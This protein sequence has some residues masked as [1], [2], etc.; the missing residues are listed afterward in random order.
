MILCYL[1][2]TKFSPGNKVK[3]QASVELRN[4]QPT[5]ISE[6]GSG[7]IWMTDVYG[8]KLSN[9]FVKGQIKNDLMKRVIISGMSGSS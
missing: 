5:D 9:E 7:R 2:E 6:L 8:C 4:Y 3:I 1:F